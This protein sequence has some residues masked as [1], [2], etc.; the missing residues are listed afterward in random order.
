M[1][2]CNR[3]IDAGIPIGAIIDA[4]IPIGAI[5]DAGIPIGAIRT[6]YPFYDK[7]SGDLVIS[8]RHSSNVYNNIV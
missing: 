5:I 1:T 4:G 6:T 7:V 3:I 8:N 2:K